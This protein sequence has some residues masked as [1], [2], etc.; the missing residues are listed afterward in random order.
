MAVIYVQSHVDLRCLVIEKTGTVAPTDGEQFHNIHKC[1]T[2]KIDR[3]EWRWRYETA[4]AILCGGYAETTGYY[5][6][7]ALGGLFV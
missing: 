7:D 6:G 4:V 2:L 5:L 1:V 3:N